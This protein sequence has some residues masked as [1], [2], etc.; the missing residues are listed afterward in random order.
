MRF[1]LPEPE[2]EQVILGNEVIVHPVLF[3][4]LNINKLCRIVYVTFFCETSN[5][6]TF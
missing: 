1:V 2:I 4:L 3:I 5:V 6:K